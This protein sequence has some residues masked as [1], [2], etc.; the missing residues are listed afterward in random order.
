V[1]HR[2]DDLELSVARGEAK[3]DVIALGIRF[4]HGMEIGAREPSVPDALHAVA[5]VVDVPQTLDAHEGASRARAA[6]GS[7]PTWTRQ[8]PNQDAWA[9]NAAAEV[10]RRATPPTSSRWRTGA[11]D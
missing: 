6:R 11:T 5:R 3:I 7:R 2:L 9:A 10:F 1:D 8:G 4:T